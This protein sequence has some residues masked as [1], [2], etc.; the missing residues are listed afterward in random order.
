MVQ[1]RRFRPRWMNGGIPHN[2]SHADC[3]K[4]FDGAAYT[5]VSGKIYCSRACRSD[6]SDEPSVEDMARRVN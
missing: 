4:A 6:M 1:I 2:C 5:G 3:Q